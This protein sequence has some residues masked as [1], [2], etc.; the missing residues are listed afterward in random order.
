MEKCANDLQANLSPDVDLEK[1]KNWDTNWH[2]EKIKCSDDKAASA[3]ATG[4][5][6]GSDVCEHFFSKVG[7]MIRNERCYDGVDLLS[8]A[9]ALN[10]LA[11]IQSSSILVFSV[12]HSKQESIW[13]AMNHA[14]GQTLA[15]LD[16][17]D[18]ADISLGPL[19]DVEEFNTCVDDEVTV[20]ECELR[21]VMDSVVDDVED[22]KCQISPFVEV[23]G[24]TICKSTLVSQ[25]NGNPTLSKDRLTRVKGGVYDTFDKKVTYQSRTCL[26]VGS[27]YAVL[28]ERL[29]SKEIRRSK[30]KGKLGSTNEGVSKGTWYLGRVVCMRRK[31]GL[32]MKETRGPIDLLDCPANVEIHLAWYQKA[33]GTRS[34]TYDLIDNQCVPLESIISIAN[35][36][37]DL[38]TKKYQLDANDYKVFNKYIKGYTISKGWKVLPLFR[39]IHHSPEFF[40]KPQK[41]DPLRFE[42]PPKPNTFMPFGNGEHSCPES[43]LAK[44]EMLVFIHHLTTKFRV[45]KP[46]QYTKPILHIAVVMA[47]AVAKNR[48]IQCDYGGFILESLVE[49]NLKGSAK[50]NPY[51]SAES[52][53]TRRAYQ[54]LDMIEDLPVANSQASLI[55]NSRLIACLVRTTTTTTSSRATRLAKKQSSSDDERSDTDKDESPKGSKEK[56]ENVPSEFEKS[57]E[58]D[59]STPLERKGTQKR[60]AP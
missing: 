57:D 38:E 40:L 4:D 26:V 25:L 33:K 36:T 9:G 14:H 58:E 3:P 17:Q 8:S 53:L 15:N 13:T 42:S 54:A 55:Y 51:M 45:Q 23:D 37:Y 59:T 24:K 19:A 46:P 21:H 35:L 28:F 49:A 2:V 6:E 43:E 47:L 16:E 29:P 44:L 1:L 5:G 7:G 60:K 22:I 52:M 11:E 31:L 50:N 48:T 20:A 10:R 12:A 39:N 34:Y 32:S 30:V 27:Y 41:C 56:E 18:T